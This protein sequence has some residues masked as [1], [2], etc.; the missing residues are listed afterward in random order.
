MIPHPRAPRHGHLVTGS[1]AWNDGGSAAIGPISTRLERVD[2]A[3]GRPAAARTRP[4]DNVRRIVRA[5][6]SVMCGRYAVSLDPAALAAEFEAVDRTE[7]AVGPDH[8]VTPTR[9]VPIVVQRAAERSVRPVRWGFVPTWVAEI[10]NGPP[11]INARAETLTGKRSFAEAAARRRCLMP[12]TG[13]FEWRPDDPR[14]QPYL[15]RG[16]DAES[17]AMAAVFST[18]WPPESPN[19]PLVNCAVVTTAAR[20]PAADIHHRMPL[21]LPADRWDEWLDPERTS[22]GALLDAEPRAYRKLR[23]NPVSVQVNSLRNNRPDL[24]E[25]TEELPMPAE[26]AALFES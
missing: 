16:Q 12:A 6:V 9:T 2:G 13:W 7:D 23:I 22:P 21:L 15:C 11:L 5:G 26:Q 10:G 17:L 19:A 14:R 24:L 8:N 18:W 4:A 25:P 1:L 3:R 20:G